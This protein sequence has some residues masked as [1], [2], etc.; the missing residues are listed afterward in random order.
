MLKPRDLAGLRG[1]TLWA[2]GQAGLVL[3]LVCIYFGVRGLTVGS[4][5][6][7][8]DHAHDIWAFEQHLH[9]DIE[10][11][12]QAPAS[13]SETVV[14]IANWIYIWGHWPIIVVTMLWLLRW[15]SDVFRRLRDAMML[16]GAIGMVL[17]ATYPVAP[18]RLAGLGLIDTVSESSR[19]YR[20][21]Q[22][23]T[24]VNQYAA[25]PS[26]HAGWDLLV[27]ISIVTAAST[28]ALR[29]IGYALPS[30]MAVAVVLTANHYV[31]DV[32]AGVLLVLLARVAA[33]ALERSRHRRRMRRIEVLVSPVVAE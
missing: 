25:M 3:V 10:E 16:S 22:P 7:A 2:M 1:G 15:H 23:P 6:D 18:P 8:L 29:I 5:E 19:A 11:A 24:F 21:L 26:L 27:G 33:L 32:V 17:Y 12:L 14:T 28:V 20:V 31:I 13:R 30:L 4:T 9:I